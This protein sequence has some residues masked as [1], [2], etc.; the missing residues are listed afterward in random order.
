MPKMDGNSLRRAW[1]EFFVE[2]GH[3]PVPS[4][5]LIPHHSRA[6][7]FT[8][9]GMN[10]FLP[11]IL[12]EEH[13]PHARAT[14][15]QKCVRI[16]GK[17]DD[18]ENIGR[19][20]HH[21]TFFEMLGNFSFG[22]YFKEQAIPLAWELSTEV[23]GYDGDR[24]WATIFL[25]DDEAF[26]IWRDVVG[27][28][29]ERIQ[30]MG[31]DN[32]WEMGDTGPCGPCS[33]LYYD[34]G[35]AY[36]EAGGPAH[37]SEERYLE[38]WNL[39][40]MQF[41]RQPDGSMPELPRKIIDTGAGFERN[42]ILLN[43]LDSIFETDVLKPIVEAAERVTGA[44]YGR[45]EPTDVALR[46][47]ADHARS[48]SFLVND[49]VFPSNEER[50]YVLRRIIRRAVR[51]A[52][53]LGVEK[54]VT[55]ALVD[56][57]VEVMGQAYPDL[58]RNADFVKGVV[59]REEDRF[60]RTLRSGMARLDEELERS[61][62]SVSGQVAFQLHDTFGFPVEL[63]REIATER[64]AA[65]D[66][67]GFEQA[68]ADQRSRAREAAKGDE[69]TD[70][71]VYRDLVE[72]F[73]T[74]EFTGYSEYQSTGRVLAVVPN[75]DDGAVD[76][77]LDRTPF[78]AEGGGQVGDIG[79]IKTETGEV[80]VLDT[81][82]PV[83]G[84]HKH[85]AQVVEGEIVPGQE[86]TATIDRE[87]RD[88]IRRNHTGTHLLH[89]ALREVLG[90]H[91]KQQGSLVAPDYLRFDFSHH[92]PVSDEEMER[93]EALVNE[94]VLNNE[95][96]RAYETSKGHAEQLGAIAFFGDK[97]GEFVRIVEAGDRSMEL[98]GGTHV[99]ALG[100]IGPVKVTSEGSIGANMRRIFALT[101][102]GTL[103]HVRH[104]E[105]LLE[106]SAEM[107]RTKP[108]ELPDAIERALARQ[109]ALED[110]LKTLRAQMAGSEAKD[111]A[112][113][114]EGG[115]VVARRDG[116]PA[117]QLKDLAVA[118]RDE[119]LKAVV[120]IGSPD[121]ERVAVVAAVTKD[122]GLEAGRLS[123]EAGRVT[124]GGGGGKGDVTTAGGKDPSKIDEAVAAVRAQLGS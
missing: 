3:T 36:G 51:Q 86:A 19:S 49:G 93:I 84:L 90:G 92:S 28:P 40:F 64:G 25:D 4:A 41:D 63:T 44:P 55:P 77:Y 81:T 120:L 114:A 42:L 96:V 76:V 31:E 71:G 54:N 12:G 59:E 100:M 101:G 52:F 18:I 62:T 87:R 29:A 91:V 53:T 56:A 26:Q 70:T 102:A 13:P 33:E 82:A 115:I 61:P 124:G 121:G 113:E 8:N 116:L 99:G 27:L 57:T 16:K 118:A 48:I 108:E 45:D 6:P 37:G 10:Q 104:E 46:I 39:V 105:Q 9:A 32:F 112:A 85:T 2:R 83:S 95:P 23:F 67:A 14:S 38:Y 5:G 20:P 47:L 17:H 21:A 80:R 11:Y 74:T 98:C 30:R 50:G 69:H 72:Q 123:G 88:A 110:E 103:E 24:I 7:M 58:V 65:V 122:S 78:Y 111:L 22:D 35:P 89:W 97:Y 109:K 94:R 15:V 43:D 75:G 119:G 107:L 106:R 73:G 60:R 117:E 34:K 68:M 1:T 66:E 79:T